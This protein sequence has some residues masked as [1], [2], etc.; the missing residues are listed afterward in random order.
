[1]QTQALSSA[2]IA[3]TTHLESYHADTSAIF[4]TLCNPSRLLPF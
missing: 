3:V 2:F 4:N 1:M